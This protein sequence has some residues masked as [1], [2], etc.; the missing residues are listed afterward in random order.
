[1]KIADGV[2]VAPGELLVDGERLIVGCGEGTALEL[3]EVQMEAKKRM[4]AA[5]FLRG[6]QVKSGERLG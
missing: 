1:M 6:Y 4:G 5:G 2:S 3:V